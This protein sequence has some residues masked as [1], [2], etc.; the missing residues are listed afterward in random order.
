MQFAELLKRIQAHD[1]Q[2]VY[3]L[4]G[5]EDY[6]LDQLEAALEEHV[7]AGGEPSFNL[8]IYYGPEVQPG[9][10]IASARSFPMMAERRLVLVREAHRL[11]KDALDALALY[12][13]DPVKSTVLAFVHRQKKGPDART[14]FGKKLKTKAVL[15]EAKALYENKVPAAVEEILQ[16]RGIGIEPKA[17]HL[18]VANLGTKLSRIATELDKLALQLPQDGPKTITASLVHAFVDIDRE[19]N[20]F[21]LTS[22]IGARR[23]LQAHTTIHYLTQ[24][25]RANPPV[26]IVGQL[27]SYF[28]KLALIKQG[29]LTSD[30]A[31]ASAL[32][33][34]PFFAKDYGSAAAKYSLPQLLRGLKAI[35]KA[36]QALKGITPTRMPEE[37]VLKTLVFELV[38]RG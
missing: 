26:L 9:A 30:S 34:P 10:L 11:K 22:H 1:F 3:Y 19:F 13:D 31:I 8:E 7:L 24:N 35:A 6:Y 32:G 36:D 17:L 38:Q 28:S 4:F 16:A 14:A 27:Y 18:L 25:L 20:V 15:F 5:E 23:A 21:E 29:N 2:P 12:L 37:H 33:V